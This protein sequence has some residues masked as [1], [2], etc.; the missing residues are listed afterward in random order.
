M[1]TMEIKKD[2]ALLFNAISD[3]VKELEEAVHR[4]KGGLRL[5][6]YVQQA[7]EEMHI[8]NSGDL[9]VREKH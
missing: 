7:T 9:V 4:L 2:Y 1:E 3:V 5:L 8:A 6:K